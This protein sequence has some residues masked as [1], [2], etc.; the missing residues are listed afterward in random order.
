MLQFPNNQIGM[1]ELINVKYMYKKV[2]VMKVS[3][4][5]DSSRLGFFSSQF[6]LS[7]H[8]T[9]SMF[10]HFTAQFPPTKQRL[11]WGVNA[12]LLILII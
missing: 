7:L 10:H 6:A 4:D 3:S 11:Q 9:F 5:S 1:Q 8:L 2:S 12:S